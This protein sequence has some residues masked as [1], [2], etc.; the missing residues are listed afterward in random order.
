MGPLRNANNR[1]WETE[2]AE[3]ACEKWG[4]LL[5][6]IQGANILQ[7]I[8]DGTLLHLVDQTDFV[9]DGIFCEHAYW[10]DFD[11]ESLIMQNALFTDKDNP[12]R[13]DNGE[14]WDDRCRWKFD[15]LA[16]NKYWK[17]TIKWR[18]DYLKQQ[19]EVEVRLAQLD[20][21]E[22]QERQAVSHSSFSYGGNVSPLLSLCASSDAS[23]FLAAVVL[24][25]RCV[26][27]KS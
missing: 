5:C 13:K 24:S 23:P 8:F 12:G 16:E 1:Q 25:F 17:P 22:E 18:D 6:W 15:Q 20:L 7:P 14:E 4:G 2:Q 11:K 21:E 26:G 10:I 9:Q 3:M 19:A 27:M